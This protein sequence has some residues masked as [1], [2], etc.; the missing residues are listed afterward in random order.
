MWDR[1]SKK[2][3]SMHASERDARRADV[4]AYFVRSRV[5]E[6]GRMREVRIP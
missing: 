4:C 6:E 3:M 2:V 1:R 5:R